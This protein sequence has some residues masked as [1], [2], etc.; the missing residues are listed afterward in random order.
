MADKV[1]GLAVGGTRVDEVQQSIYKAEEYGIEAAWMT[2]GGAR[3][4]SMTVFAAAA[5]GHREPHRRDR[6]AGYRS[7]LR[8]L[9]SIVRTGCRPSR[10]VPGPG[11]PGHGRPAPGPGCAPQA[12][13]LGEDQLH[14]VR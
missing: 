13:V 1:I 9:A 11:E 2:T 4:D 14:P 8:R 5:G 7:P 6:A 12:F 10:L 3:L